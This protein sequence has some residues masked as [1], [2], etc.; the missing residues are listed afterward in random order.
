MLSARSEELLV[1]VTGDKRT[2]LLEILEGV[3]EKYARGARN[4]GMDLD[5]IP[6]IDEAIAEAEDYLAYLRQYRR[7]V[8]RALMLIDGGNAQEARGLLA[9]Q[10]K[11]KQTHTID[12]GLK[13]VL[14][15][16]ARDE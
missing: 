3:I 4:H 13:H 6:N 7:I 15:E 5:D 2:M 16:V 14:E 11:P 1:T 9:R 10:F 12:P 8:V